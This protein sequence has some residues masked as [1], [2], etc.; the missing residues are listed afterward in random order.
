MS[1]TRSW[2]EC[3]PNHF[4]WFLTTIHFTYGLSTWTTKWS[5]GLIKRKRSDLIGLSTDL[6]QLAYFSLIVMLFLSCSM[7]KFHILSVS[8][9][10]SLSLLAF[11]TMFNTFRS[12]IDFPA[13]V[14][15]LGKEARPPLSILRPV[16]ILL[17][18]SKLRHF[19][20]RHLHQD[21]LEIT[22][23]EALPTM[24]NIDEESIF[25]F[26]KYLEPLT[27]RGVTIGELRDE[28]VC[29]IF[30]TWNV[31]APACSTY[32]VGHRWRIHL[33]PSTLNPWIPPQS[34]LTNFALSLL[35]RSF[36]LERFDFL[37]LYS[38]S[39]LRTCTPT[40]FLFKDEIVFTKFSA[41]F[42][43]VRFENK[44]IPPF[45]PLLLM[46]H[47]KPTFCA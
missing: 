22:S 10:Q 24:Y 23:C 6:S 12:C 3:R 39:T 9:A 5:I 14:E 27:I 18:F 36:R 43:L 8:L 1:G 37:S 47:I 26:A 13:H 7:L 20:T 45:L 38:T 46:D 31:R 32:D 17:N 34:A 11:V 2:S 19:V 33:K 35:P 44:S 30:Q 25:T 28:I 21:Q 4:H 42:A 29:Q 16:L 41:L 15:Y 40:P